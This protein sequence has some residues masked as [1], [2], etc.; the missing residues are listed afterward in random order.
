LQTQYR[1]QRRYPNRTGSALTAANALRD[2][3]GATAGRA[4]IILD[5]AFALALRA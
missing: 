5:A 1:V 2:Q 3:A 4:F